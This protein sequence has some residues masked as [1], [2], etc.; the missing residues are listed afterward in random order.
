MKPSGNLGEHEGFGALSAH[1]SFIVVGKTETGCDWGVGET[2]I[3]TV[4]VDRY[5]VSG[6]AV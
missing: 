6:C 1:I 4:G 5:V 3:A 2:V